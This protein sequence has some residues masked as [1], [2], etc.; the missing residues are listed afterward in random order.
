M[1]T[2]SNKTYEFDLNY[3]ISA[4]NLVGNHAMESLALQLED[5]L[6]NEEKVSTDTDRV[7]DYLIEYCYAT[8]E[9]EMKSHSED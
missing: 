6:V 8:L 2:K 3:I 9:S 1:T 7:M 5:L 4:S